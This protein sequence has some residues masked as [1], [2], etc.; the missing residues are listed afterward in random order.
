[1]HLAA[2]GSIEELQLHVARAEEF[3]RDRAETAVVVLDATAMW[4]KLR[5]EDRV[6]L[7]DDEQARQ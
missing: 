2:R 6:Y 1:M 4:L 5:G 3:V 7:C